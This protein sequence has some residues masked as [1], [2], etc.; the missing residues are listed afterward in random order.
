VFPGTNERKAN[1]ALKALT[2]GSDFKVKDLRTY[3][4]NRLA[5]ETMEGMGPPAT[6]TE[7]RRLRKAVAVAVSAR[8][9]NTPDMAL[10]SYINPAVFADWESDL[11]TGDFEKG[12]DDV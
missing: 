4:A 1:L 7:F 12:L 2:G 10:S 11:K 8:L 3:L 6:M 9:G 5:L